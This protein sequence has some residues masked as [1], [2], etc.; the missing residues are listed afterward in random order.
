MRSGE[1]DERFRPAG[2]PD[3]SCGRVGRGPGVVLCCV[4]VRVDRHSMDV[5][6]VRGG[7]TEHNAAVMHMPPPSFTAE[8]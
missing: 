7:H 6:A 4:S 1:G 3:A 8:A 5:L 2:R